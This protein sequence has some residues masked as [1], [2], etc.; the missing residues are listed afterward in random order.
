MEQYYNDVNFLVLHSSYAREWPFLEVCPEVVRGEGRRE[1]ERGEW[2]STGTDPE[3]LVTNTCKS[4]KKNDRLYNS[5]S[6]TFWTARCHR[7]G[8]PLSGGRKRTE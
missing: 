3:S 5:A 1:A 6:R 4:E 7:D 2:E 8:E